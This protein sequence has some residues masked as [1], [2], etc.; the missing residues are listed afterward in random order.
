MK[1]LLVMSFVVAAA[2]FV[3]GC[4][5][6]EP[7]E[8]VEPEQVVEESMMTEPDPLA[9]IPEA[10]E[11]GPEGTE[12]DPPVEVVQIPEGAWYCDM[13]TVH[14]ARM[15][16]GDGKCAICGM[17]LVQ[18]TGEPTTAEPMEAAGSAAGGDA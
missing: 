3:L 11:V 17:N 16:E 13:G 10:V 12:F 9:E 15:A 18:K 5:G 8:A 4:G 7:Q 1:K 14:Y 6:G 2:A